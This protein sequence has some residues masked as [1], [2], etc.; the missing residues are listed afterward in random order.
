MCSFLDDKSANSNISQVT[1]KTLKGCDFTINPSFLNSLSSSASSL[2]NSQNEHLKTKGLDK[3]VPEFNPPMLSKTN[4]SELLTNQNKL[5]APNT[6]ANQEKALIHNTQVDKSIVPISNSHTKEIKR[7]EPSLIPEAPKSVVPEIR[8]SVNVPSYPKNMDKSFKEKPSILS[9]VIK[10]DKLLD[11][12]LNAQ[13]TANVDKKMLNQDAQTAE[14]KQNSHSNKLEISNLETNL[15]SFSVSV[16]ENNRHDNSENISCHKDSSTK[17]KPQQ[18]SPLDHHDS[19]N[20]NLLDNPSKKAKISSD[21]F[22]SNT[23]PLMSIPT[24]KWTGKTMPDLVNKDLFCNDAS[25]EIIPKEIPSHISSHDDKLIK[26]SLEEN[27]NKNRLTTENDKKLTNENGFCTD[28]NDRTLTRKEKSCE[29]DDRI[30]ETNYRRSAERSNQSKKSYE[31]SSNYFDRDSSRERY[32][33]YNS[34]NRHDSYYKH[35]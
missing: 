18:S 20:C 8:K 30:P 29:K 19:T 4:T 26:K 11:S 13:I 2:S 23:V 32:R 12:H 24:P 15:T 10:S 31:R 9:D 33:R 21:I 25:G 34:N 7:T 22:Q 5:I 16:L 6:N 28:N 35:K 14:N 17:N 1:K 27:K 3:L